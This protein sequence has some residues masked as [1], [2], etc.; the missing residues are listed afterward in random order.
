MPRLDGW[1]AMSEL[2]RH[3]ETAS[4][5]I[6]VLTGHE[7]KHELKPAALAI[8]ACSFLTKPTL[9][10]ELALEIQAHLAPQSNPAADAV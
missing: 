4:I 9:P 8:G 5:P 6:I 7:F 10:A 1:G 3:S 2:R